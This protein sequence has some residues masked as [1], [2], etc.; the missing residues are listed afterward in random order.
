MARS[1]I[2][3]P[4]CHIGNPKKGSDPQGS[5]RWRSMSSSKS[6]R[7]RF[8]FSSGGHLIRVH[9]PEVELPGAPPSRPIGRSPRSHSGQGGGGG[10][11]FAME[12]AVTRVGSRRHRSPTLGKLPPPA[13]F[14]KWSAGLAKR[15]RSARA[16]PKLKQRLQF[17][18]ELQTNRRLG[19]SVLAHPRSSVS[20]QRPP[21]GGG[22]CLQP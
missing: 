3:H 15:K 4:P 10:G 14:E 12:L 5:L 21:G 22:K 19:T 18:F 1:K 9:T 13:G 6:P 16:S 17:I 2:R 7:K 8:L 20:F 11:G